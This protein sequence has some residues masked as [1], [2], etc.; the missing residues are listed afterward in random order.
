MNVSAYELVNT[1][2]TDV[3]YRVKKKITKMA[4]NCLQVKAMNIAERWKILI[5]WPLNFST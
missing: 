1:N 2:K 5:K 4:T 3:Y